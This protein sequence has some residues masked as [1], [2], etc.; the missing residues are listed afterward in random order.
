MVIL[1]F[2]MYK[3]FL[4]REQNNDEII[5]E[6]KYNSNENEGFNSYLKNTSSESNNYKDEN[7]LEYNSPEIAEVKKSTKPTIKSEEKKVVSFDDMPIKS[8]YN[9]K[10]TEKMNFEDKPL[11][12]DDIPIKPKTNDFWL[13]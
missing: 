9:S 3:L 4:D 7:K 13:Y 6:N 2:I 11:N 8:N 1:L 10:M 12:I 5:V